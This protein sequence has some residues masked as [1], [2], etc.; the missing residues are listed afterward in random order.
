MKRIRIKLTENCNVFFSSDFHFDHG[1]ICL[2]ST[3][4]I[5]TPKPYAEMSK[6]ERID[7]SLENGVRP[8]PN[9]DQMNES[10]ID[11]INNMVGPEDHLFHLGD[12]TFRNPEKTRDRLVCQNV[13]SIYG[14]HDKEIDDIKDKLRIHP[15]P[16]IEL[17]VDGQLICLSHYKH[18][19]WNKRHHGSWHLYGHSHSNFEHVKVGRSMD[20]GVDNAFRL[21]GDYRPF[22]FEEVK[23]RIGSVDINHFSINGREYDVRD[24][25][26]RE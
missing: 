23:E 14:N 6:Q 18:L 4:W 21:L 15:T 20:V 12:W 19:V 9:V 25:H 3:K 24:H 5:K 16:A 17:E 8:F 1:N 22:S 2:G 26:D 11:S 7:L 10:I 13:Y